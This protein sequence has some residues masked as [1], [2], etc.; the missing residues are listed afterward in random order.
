MKFCSLV[1]GQSR[2]TVTIPPTSLTL[3]TASTVTINTTASTSSQINSATLSNLTTS[4]PTPSTTSQ[5]TSTAGRNATTS[6]FSV[7]IL[8][9]TTAT[10][11]A[12]GANAPSQNACNTSSSL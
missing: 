7:T 5:P 4:G 10:V 6:H 2:N 8:L 3:K 1:T 11:P 9:A 12:N